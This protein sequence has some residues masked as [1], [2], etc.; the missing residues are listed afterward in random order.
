MIQ[1]V[2]FD[3]DSTLVTVEGIN[4]LARLKGKEGQVSNLIRQAVNGE[5][6]LHQAFARRLEIIQPTRQDLL[7]VGEVYIQNLTPG[8]QDV[9]RG[10]L[11][12]G[13]RVY[14]ISGG[15]KLALDIL[16]KHLQIPQER[17]FGVELDFDAGGNYLG[18]DKSQAL[19]TNAG[20]KEL[21]G[22]LPI[23]LAQTAMIGDGANDLDVQEIVK[24]FIGFRGERDNEF[25]RQKAKI[26]IDSHN[27]SQVL[28]I[29]EGY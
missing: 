19:T 28:E 6:P 1:N 15:Y 13:R 8:A 16:A 24:L 26:F 3:C 5:I 2:F 25:M 11:D 18:Y 4:E 22:K 20:K 9:V 12:D 21:I 27:L 17:V 10:L 7:Q 29:I 14:I 23:D